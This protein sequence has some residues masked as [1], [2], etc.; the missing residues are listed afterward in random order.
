M[1]EFVT[2][3]R[4]LEYETIKLSHNYSAILTKHLVAKKD[5]YGTF[6]I[7]CTI[8][9]CKFSKAICDVGIDVLSKNNIFDAQNVEFCMFSK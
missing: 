9:G 8:R 1:K 7:P 3:K 6:I 2:K 4:I 5:D